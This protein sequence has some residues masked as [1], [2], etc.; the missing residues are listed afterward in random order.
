MIYNA[1][2]NGTTGN[3][4]LYDK[5]DINL[6]WYQIVVKIKTLEIFDS[7]LLRD[8]ASTFTY[9]SIKTNIMSLKCV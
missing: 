3:Y 8:Y 4:L 6:L 9:K 5:F 1:D 7:F 2:K